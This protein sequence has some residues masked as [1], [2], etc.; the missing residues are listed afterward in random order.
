MDILSLLVIILVTSNRG[1]LQECNEKVL[2]IHTLDSDFNFA[3]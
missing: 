3:L 2:K 1:V